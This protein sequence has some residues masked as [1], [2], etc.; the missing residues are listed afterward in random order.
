MNHIR[1]L[2]VIDRLASGVD[3]LTGAVFADDSPLQQAD[4][5]RALFLAA[6]AL[7]SGGKKSAPAAAKPEAISKAGVAWAE[8]EDQQL[9]GAFDA[10]TAI[11]DAG[12]AIK[13]LAQTHRRSAGAIS[14]RLIKIE[15]GP[16]PERFRRATG[17]GA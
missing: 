7:R 8:A 11:K 16:Q 6:A 14:A 17:A 15:P 5:V 2:E 3:P 4:V 9:G 1:A 13:E 10:G 12:T